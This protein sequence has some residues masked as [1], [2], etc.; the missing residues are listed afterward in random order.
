MK[1]MGST[2]PRG[3]LAAAL[4]AYAAWVVFPMLWV[5]YSSL[6]PDGAIFLRPFSP[7]AWS[8]L[9]TA[10]Y[11]QAW[12]EA[13]F[14]DYFLNSI[15]V[16]GCSVAL[17]V[18]LGAMAA[19]ALARFVL[20]AGRLLFWLF[21]AGL[22]VPAQLAVVP[23]FFELRGLGLLNSRTGLILAYTANGLPFAIFILA[24]FFRTLPRAL[25]EAAVID[26]C[27]E[28]SAFWR[29][30]LPLAR[31]GL[32]TVAIFQF[33]GIWKEY[34]YAFML[35]GGET[36]AGGAGARTLPLGLANL[37]IEAEY[38]A[39]YGM[40]FAGLVLVTIPILLVYLLLQRHIVKGIAAGA[41]KG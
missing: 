24:G 17:V 23:L 39:T 36:P 1:P 4:L 19:Y 27:G 25:Y 37:S 38:H 30:L 22:M 11:T 34:F 2:L 32:V 21:M 16:T 6:K 12:R 10:N 20:P 7:P 31:P 33:I 15:A 3:L 14:R 41:L 28:F 40:L 18:G 26:G 8:E 35:A 29:V 13:R 9:Q 5:A